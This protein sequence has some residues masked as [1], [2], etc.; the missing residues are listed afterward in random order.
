[1]GSI[2]FRHVTDAEGK[3]A[4]TALGGSPCAEPTDYFRGPY[5][6]GN[7]NGKQTGCT[8]GGRSHL[9]ARYASGAGQGGGKLDLRLTSATRW[10]GSYRTDRG[11]S[12][13]Y[14]ASF[15]SHFA[16]DGATA[17][18]GTSAKCDTKTKI[19]TLVSVGQS[20][21][22]DGAKAPLGK[23]KTG[24]TLQLSGTVVCGGIFSHR[25]LRQPTTDEDDWFVDLKPTAVVF[26]PVPAGANDLNIAVSVSRSFTPGCPVG[27]PGI[28]NLTDGGNDSSK[29][30]LRVSV[31]RHNHV[32]TGGGNNK[33]L[34]VGIN[35]S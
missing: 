23:T 1:V 28:L 30:R 32:Y 25:D 26:P 31:C 20:G 10:S 21:L 34:V 7:D 18:G 16:G 33:G 8:V 24:G 17:G 12:G 5:V 11:A 29:D 4:L 19:T 27:A 15:K 14:S 2:G 3:Q 6:S 13:S 35:P 9:V 22:P